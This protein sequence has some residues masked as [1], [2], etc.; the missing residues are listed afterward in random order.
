[1]PRAGLQHPRPRPLI[2]SAQPLD[3]RPCGGRCGIV[4]GEGDVVAEADIV[5]AI[6]DPF[7]EGD[8]SPP[9][10]ITQAI[11]VGRAVVPIVHEGDALFHNRRCET[12][13]HGR[14]GGGRACPPSW[15]SAAVLNEDENH[16]NR[17]QARA[18]PLKDAWMITLQY[19]TGP[20][21]CAI[22]WLLEEIGVPYDVFVLHER[23]QGNQSGTEGGLLK[24][25][26]AGQNP[27]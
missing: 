3:A 22:L 20:A 1:M 23:E 15:R 10:K 25:Q 4:Q 19:S 2:C 5:S 8:A 9:S 18:N 24:V 11:I 14:G 27:P 13:R 21:R 17:L 7:G 26:S 12:G 6:S 16:L